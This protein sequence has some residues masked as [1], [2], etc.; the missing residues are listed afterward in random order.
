ML[1]TNTN[2][3]KRVFMLSIAYLCSLLL[4]AFFFSHIIVITRKHLISYDSWVYFVHDWVMPDYWE[5]YGGLIRAVITAKNSICFF[6]F[7]WFF[8]YICKN[9]KRFSTSLRVCIM[10]YLSLVILDL[11]I[12]WYIRYY[13]DFYRIY[14]FGIFPGFLSCFILFM[15]IRA[16]KKRGSSC[17]CSKNSDVEAGWGERSV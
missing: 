5:K 9:T 11:G 15:M 7:T 12:S 14:M 4:E 8:L 13:A 1:A 2:R 6:I 10:S 17:I 3:E 16:S